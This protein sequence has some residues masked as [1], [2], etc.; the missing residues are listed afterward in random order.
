MARQFLLVFLLAAS[1]NA[2]A[3]KCTNDSLAQRFEKAPIVFVGTTASSL[4]HPGKAGAT[5]S[6]TI[7]RSLKGAPPVGASLSVDPL[8]DTDCT[9]P[10]VPKAKLVVFAYP[11]QGQPPVTNACS[12]LA[13]EPFT[14]GGTVMRPSSEVVQFL[15]SLR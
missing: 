11:R 8:Y 12:I 5:A 3:C 10:L 7:S 1:G 2:F 4:E 14:V 15:Q 9:A 6:F 13:A